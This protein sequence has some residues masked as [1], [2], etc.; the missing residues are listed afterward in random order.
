MEIQCTNL[1]EKRIDKTVRYLEY[2]IS[3]TRM[4]HDALCLHATCVHL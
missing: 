1:E 4:Y 2:E 3:P